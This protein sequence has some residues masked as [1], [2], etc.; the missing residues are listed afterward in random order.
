MK[1]RMLLCF[2]LAFFVESAMA[3]Q[4][5]EIKYAFWG[6][7]D[8][9]GVEKDIIEA[10][11]AAHPDGK[12]TPIAVDYGNYH[13]K[14]LVMIAGGQPPDVMRID[15][16]FFQDFMKA[17]AL[18]NITP[19]IR[20]DKLDLSKYYPAG[21]AD[22]RSGSDY[23]G[24]PWGTAPN[25]MI[26]NT[27]MFADA[28]IP[29]PPMNWTWK[30]FVSIAR[31]LSMGSGET[32]QYGFVYSLYGLDFFLPFMWMEGEDLFDKTRTKFTL[33]T[34]GAAKKVEELKSL[35]KE[36]VFTNPFELIAMDAT[37]RYLSQNRV[38]MMI[39]QA[40]T[41]LSLQKIDGFDF[42]VRPIPGTAKYPAVTTYK[43]NIIA[44]SAGSKKEQAA[45]DFLKFLRGPDL[46]GE[47]L[48]MKAKRMPP[49]FD[50]QILWDTYADASKPPKDIVPITKEMA[51]KY[52][53]LLP[54]RKGWMEVQSLVLQS[55]Q[56]VFADKATA[57]E[58]LSDIAPKVQ[59]VLD[60]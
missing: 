19:L 4:K 2:A 23:Y 60:K 6:N 36:G 41:L 37:L 5:V 28:G 31:K 14:L 46:E 56:N 12:V 43:S 49:T 16:F 13:S 48:Y 42:A 59:A 18:K 53:H 25:Y 20:K 30:D 3:A 7:P 58:A 38:A 54:L 51:A 10:Y 57:S 11:E 55:L 17:R 27:K 40:N 29:L 8:A 32:K 44:I 45:W 22:C 39:G 1:L 34:P 52:G 47:M 50:V 9:I 33:N 26:L 35:V 21:L 15:S 24:L